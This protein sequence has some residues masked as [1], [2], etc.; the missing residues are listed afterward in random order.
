MLPVVVGFLLW[1]TIQYI[2]YQRSHRSNSILGLNDAPE[3][4][5][6]LPA[7]QPLVYAKY[8]TACGS[9]GF[10]VFRQEGSPGIEILLWLTFIVPGIIYSI[11]RSSTRKWV[12]ASCGNQA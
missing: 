1:G 7:P 5:P 2:R 11:W 9:V 8:C 12:C 4:K 3:P 10:P 6:L